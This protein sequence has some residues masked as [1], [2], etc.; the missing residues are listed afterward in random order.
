MC[1]DLLRKK[2]R[3]TEP[4]FSILTLRAA[5]LTTIWEG[6]PGRKSDWDQTGTG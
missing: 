6:F 1:F 4:R 5:D 2:G 3:S